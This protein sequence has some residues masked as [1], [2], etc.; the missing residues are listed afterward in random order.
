MSVAGVGLL[1]F[2]F[3]SNFGPNDKCC[4][5]GSYGKCQDRLLPVPVAMTRG[6]KRAEGLPR[7]C[8]PLGSTRSSFRVRAFN[9]DDVAS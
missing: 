2:L 9:V 3:L 7:I 1:L 8:M 5:A 6:P 4:W